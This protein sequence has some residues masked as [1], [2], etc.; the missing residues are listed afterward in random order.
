[1]KIF[2][3]MMVM[4]I[5]G[6]AVLTPYTYISANNLTDTDADRI[7]SIVV[8]RFLNADTTSDENVT[9]DEDPEMRFGGDFQGI[10]DNLDY[11][12]KMGFTAI[13]LSP[14]FKF[15]DDDYLGYDVESYDEIDPGL[16]GEEG[17]NDLVDAAHDMDLEVFVDLPAVSVDGENAAEDVNVNEIYGDYLNEKDI[18]ILD[19]TDESVQSEYQD[20]VQTFVDDFNIDGVSMMVAQD[21]VNASEIL[22]GG[23]KTYGFLTTED[24]VAGGFDYMA[25]ESMR[26][27]LAESFATVDREVPEIPDSENMLLVDHWFS[28]RFTSHAVEENMFPGTRVKQVMTYMYSHPGPVGMLYG[29]EVAFNGEEM[30]TIHPQMD[31][32]TDQE[33]V[34]YL[35]HINM[36]FQDHKNVLS[37]EL[38]TLHNNDG[39]YIT[40]YHTNEVDFILNVNDT[41]A[42]HGVNL[43]LDDVEDNQVL[44]GMLIGDM[45]RATSPGEYIVVL[46]REETELYAVIEEQGFNNGY[47]IASIIIFGGFAVFIFFAA[48]NGRKHK[49]KKQS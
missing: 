47:I 30:P 14:V 15:S 25:I 16:G 32:W 8:D 18:D 19:L 43:A 2:K 20:M 9:V 13:H 29:T 46:D 34:E 33:V 44:S 4:F 24:A 7:Y 45:V 28:E 49:K 6:A 35:E 39:H 38:E 31:L 1:M 21:D 17:L 26:T 5:T 23:I 22:P 10:E 11:I 36:V 41:S 37:G 27:E 48:W 3:L 12:K 40:R 42:T